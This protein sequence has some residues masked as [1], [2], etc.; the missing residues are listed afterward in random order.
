MNEKLE[1]WKQRFVVAE[2]DYSAR[3][4]KFDAWTK[5]YKGDKEIVTDGRRGKNAAIVRNFTFELIESQLA[6][7]LNKHFANSHA[8]VA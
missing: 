1:I 2:A 6:K 3:L 5:Q 8:H 4:A 7:W